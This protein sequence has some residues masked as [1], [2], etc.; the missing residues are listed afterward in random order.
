MRYN[1][2]WNVGL[3]KKKTPTMLQILEIL[4]YEGPQTIEEIASKIGKHY[5]TAMRRLKEMYENLWVHSEEYL[6]SLDEETPRSFSD[7]PQRYVVAETGLIVYFLTHSKEALSRFGEI[8]E[9]HSGMFLTFKWYPYFVSKGLGDVIKDRFMLALM[10]TRSEMYFTMMLLEESVYSD[11]LDQLSR[12]S[13]FFTERDRVRLDRV[14]F[15][16][17]NFLF[18]TPKSLEM[19]ELQLVE[20]WGFVVSKNSLITFFETNEGLRRLREVL[21]AVDENLELYRFKVETLNEYSMS[22][23]FMKEDVEKWIDANNLG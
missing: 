1:A 18:N 10:N 7:G 8:A 17:N 11:D 13:P 22:L 2:E 21:M 20:G 16:F 9:R 3:L 12:Y 19:R 5:T 14:A 23:G 15:G 4:I 6:R